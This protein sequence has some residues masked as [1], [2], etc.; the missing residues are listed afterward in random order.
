MPRVLYKATPC[1]NYDEATSHIPT[2]LSL[3]IMSNLE[4]IYKFGLSFIIAVFVLIGVGV[5]VGLNVSDGA[6]P[7]TVTTTPSAVDTSMPA[8]YVTSTA[9]AA[10]ATPIATTT[11]MIGRIPTASTMVTRLRPK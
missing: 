6:P 2:T 3:N 10:I 8:T 11:T 9:P 1:L 4:R 7:A 5:G